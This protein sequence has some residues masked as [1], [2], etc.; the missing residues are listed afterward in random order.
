MYKE[1]TLYTMYKGL[2]NMYKVIY[3]MYTG[4]ALYNMYK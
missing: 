4:Q 2:Y 3:N 1:H